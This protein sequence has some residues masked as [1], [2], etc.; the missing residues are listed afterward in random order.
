METISNQ[1]HVSFSYEGSTETYTNDS[2][3]VNSSMKDKYSISVE[4]T[5]TTTCWR[6]GDTISYS[7]RV[8]NTGCCCL[9]RFIITDTSESSEYLTFVEGSA[10]IFINGSMTDIT[11]TEFDP[12]TF[13]VL[14]KLEKDE[15]FVLQY[16]MVVSDDIS[17]EIT[18]I[19][20]EVNIR[21]YPCGCGCDD[22]SSGDFIEEST[23]LSIQKC[24]FAEV[25]ITKAISNDSLCCGDEI[26]YM[27]TLTNIGTVDATNVII[28]DNLPET[29]TLTE[30][31][32]ENNGVH[33]KYDT[34]EY[35][36][37]EANF[38]TLPNETGTAIYIP[39]IAPGVDNTTRIRLHG[40]M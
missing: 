32:S 9:G 20:N 7:V 29:F 23:S 15:E 11:P 4:K 35:D 14:G 6:A 30:V 28:T 31:H 2:N 1:A 22:D 10:K 18:D 38:L 8:T 21:A 25:L 27:I 36:L 16:S 5:S 12:L 39:A 33:Y 13:N 3:I 37:D 24:E 40:H 26:D 17:S 19:V 34:S